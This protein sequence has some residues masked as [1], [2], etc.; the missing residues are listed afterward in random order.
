M[1][2]LYGAQRVHS[3]ARVEGETPHIKHIALW[4]TD[5]NSQ[6]RGK[7]GYKSEGLKVYVKKSLTHM[8]IG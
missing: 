3:V 7:V 8:H 2:V 4:S 5:A 1:I 6:A